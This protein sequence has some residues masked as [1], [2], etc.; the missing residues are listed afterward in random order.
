MGNDS[1]DLILCVSAQC[2]T[3]FHNEKCFIFPFL[4]SVVNKPEVIT[5]TNLF[6]S[7]FG[8]AV[9]DIIMKMIQFYNYNFYYQQQ[10]LINDKW[11]KY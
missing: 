1:M 3:V 4:S 10:A 5:H 2:N 7:L 9:S 11:L 8:Q 6:H